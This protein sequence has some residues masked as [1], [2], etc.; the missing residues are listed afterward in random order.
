VLV[1]G[2]VSNPWGYT[3]TPERALTLMKAA[4]PPFGR[5]D[6]LLFSHAHR[7]HFEPNMALDV[8]SSQPQ[9]VLVGDSLVTGELQE[10]GRD[11]FKALSPRVKTMDTKM[12]ERTDLV[13]N[14][15]PLTVLGVN[16]GAADRPYLTLG[17]IMQLGEFRI[18]HQGDIFPDSNLPFLAS[19]A[20]EKEN[21][22]IAFFDPFFF[23]NEETKRIVLERIRPSAIILMHI[24]DDE[25]EDFLGRTRPS[26][27]QVLAFRGPMESK[28]FVK[29]VR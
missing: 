3:N 20:W 11:A 19:I 1:D 10:T 18:Y 4:Q 21:I 12:G 14:G 17:Y 25:V 7:D 8:L 24:R 23:Q 13:V 29:P 28:V 15:I 5:I 26:V 6:L 16:H 22:D 9:A 27:P 2:L